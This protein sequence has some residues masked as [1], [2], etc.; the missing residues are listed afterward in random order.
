MEPGWL[1][2]REAV[3]GQS[4]VGP[5]STSWETRALTGS[6]AAMLAPGSG[7]GV[8]PTCESVL[9]RTETARAGGASGGSGQLRH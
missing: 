6:Q 1:L 8:W 7:C 3:L 2:H 9:A 4:S 5:T